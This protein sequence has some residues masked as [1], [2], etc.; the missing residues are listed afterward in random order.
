MTG[1]QVKFKKLDEKFIR[2]MKLCDGSIVS[3][4]GKGSILFQCKNSDLCLFTKV[5]YIPSLKNNII[6][7]GQMTEEGSRVVIVGSLLK[8]YDRNG[9]LLMKAIWSRN[10]LYKLLLKDYQHLPKISIGIDSKKVKKKPTGQEKKESKNKLRSNQRL[11]QLAKCNLQV[12]VFHQTYHLNQGRLEEDD[13]G[14]RKMR[15]QTCAP[16]KET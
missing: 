13:R 2:N 5:Y 7:L 3:I 11:L 4:Q 16:N 10:R 14:I 8:I 15:F 9:A 6:F 12:D 1:D